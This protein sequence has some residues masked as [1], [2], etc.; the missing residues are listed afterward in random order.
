MITDREREVLSLIADGF[1]CDEIAVALYV[2]PHTVKAHI[3]NLYRRLDA[4]CAAEAV[5][6]GFREGVLA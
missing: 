2:S 3:K 5:A 6:V 4:R 1:T